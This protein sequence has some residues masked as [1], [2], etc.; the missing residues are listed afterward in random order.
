[1]RTSGV[2]WQDTGLRGRLLWAPLRVKG[3]RSS[4]VG[5]PLKPGACRTQRRPSLQGPWSDP[6]M[7]V[8]QRAVMAAA[9]A[10]VLRDKELIH[11]HVGS[12]EN[13][14]EV[15]FKDLLSEKDDSSLLN[16]L[17]K[18]EEVKRVE[19]E[20]DTISISK[21]CHYFPVFYLQCEFTDIVNTCA[22]TSRQESPSNVLVLSQVQVLPTSHLVRHQRNMSSTPYI[23]YFNA[24][25][26]YSFQIV[27]SLFCYFN[28][29]F[30]YYFIFTS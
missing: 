5:A 24:H 25:K 6:Q 17:D 2:K 26:L 13:Q 11:G 27:R 18:D 12:D 22:S 29:H 15:A 16:S 30:Y 23:S 4:I 21:A 9:V 3:Q 7:Q 19:S 10:A 28:I 20:V 8:D 1:M 14:N